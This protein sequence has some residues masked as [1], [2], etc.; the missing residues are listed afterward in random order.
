MEGMTFKL[1]SGSVK[2]GYLT[3]FYFYFTTFV[4]SLT[5]CFPNHSASEISK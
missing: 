2:F 3:K 4:R 1:S 5:D